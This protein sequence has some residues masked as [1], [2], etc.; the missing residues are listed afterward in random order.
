M[1]ILLAVQKFCQV[2]VLF[3]GAGV[4]KEMQTRVVRRMRV[5]E[6][7]SS[8][9]NI[10]GGSEDRRSGIDVTARKLIRSMAARQRRRIV[11]EGK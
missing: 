4:V 5:E 9:I 2:W 8:N 7:E 11:R 10:D 6:T 3:V 1:P